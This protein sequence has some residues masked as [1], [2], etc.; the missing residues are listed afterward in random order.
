MGR[1]KIDSL[2]KNRFASQDNL[3]EVKYP[4]SKRCAAHRGPGKKIHHPD[5]KRNVDIGKQAHST[6]ENLYEARLPQNQLEEL[7]GIHQKAAEL[8]KG[9]KP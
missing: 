2:D 9:K 6:D 7:E 8:R 1:H 4:A 3:G 5:M